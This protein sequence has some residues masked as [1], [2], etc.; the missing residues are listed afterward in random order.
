[1]VVGVKRVYRHAYHIYIQFIRLL[2]ISF[3]SVCSLVSTSLVG[4]TLIPLLL[5][6][7]R[8]CAIAEVED[9]VWPHETKCL[10]AT[11]SL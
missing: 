3:V 6:R 10:P 9:R 7:R 8:G 4:Q 5:L 2:H 11:N 1:M